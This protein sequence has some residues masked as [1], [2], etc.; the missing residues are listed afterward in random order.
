MSE[1]GLK[2]VG[3]DTSGNAKPISVD[4]TGKILTTG[5]SEI[6]IFSVD[7]KLP[8]RNAD[9]DYQ[10][11]TAGYVKAFNLP[12]L[13]TPYA[14]EG[15]A[16]KE[17]RNIF[18]QT[19]IIWSSLDIAL[20]VAFGPMDSTDNEI[21]NPMY[22]L[23]IGSIP[24]ASATNKPQRMILI[25]EKSSYP[26]TGYNVVYEVAELRQPVPAFRLGIAAADNTAVPTQGEIKI[27][28][29]RRY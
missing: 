2:F 7:N 27:M 11:R 29:V 25:P 26:M 19:I 6:V 10:P 28:C 14:A 23:S 1:Q 18:D 9:T 3:K 4:P 13:W 22:S 12:H 5:R 17:Y 24:A 20:D 16:K 8:P 15:F 21:G